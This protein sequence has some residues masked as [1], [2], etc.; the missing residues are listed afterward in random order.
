MHTVST[1][2]RTEINSVYIIVNDKQC[3]MFVV[4]SP[5]HREPPLDRMQLQDNMYIILR[6][7]KSHLEA[8]GYEEAGR[9]GEEIEDW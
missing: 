4:Y 2:N 6:H 7:F 1:N 8:W 3:K 5:P 9:R